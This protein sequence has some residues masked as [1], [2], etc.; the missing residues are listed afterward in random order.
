MQET[1]GMVKYECTSSSF[2]FSLDFSGFVWNLVCNLLI[3]EKIRS[4]GYPLSKRTL[5]M[6]LV[7]IG[8]ME[9]RMRQQDYSVYQAIYSTSLV[10]K[11]MVRMIV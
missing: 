5:I 6:T 11:R 7:E 4:R 3:E 8:F 10:C 2:F 1:Y 9:L